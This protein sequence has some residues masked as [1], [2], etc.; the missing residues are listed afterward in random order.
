M[1]RRVTLFAALALTLL[2]LA[3]TDTDRSLPVP[4]APPPASTPAPV[5][6]SFPADE[7]PHENRLEWWYYSG[8]L[9]DAEGARYGFPL[10][11]F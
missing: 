4:A 3:C 11:G 5:T 9:T 10:V 8:S 1:N 7:G 2:A 6:I